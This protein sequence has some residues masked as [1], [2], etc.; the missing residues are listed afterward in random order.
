MLSYGQP[1]IRF[2]LYIYLASAFLVTVH[3][4]DAADAIA[5]GV[6]P[7]TSVQS[8]SD[9]DYVATE[10]HV[11]ENRRSYLQENSVGYTTRGRLEKEGYQVTWEEYDG[12][13]HGVSEKEISDIGDWLEQFLLYQV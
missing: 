1:M 11:V 13:A 5:E 3:A 6:S 9:A 10:G 12:M 7:K 8:E 4:Q 2:G